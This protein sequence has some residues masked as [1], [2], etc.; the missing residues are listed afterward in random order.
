MGEID[1]LMLRYE[2]ES[3]W[4]YGLPAPR[5]DQPTERERI[6]NALATVGPA[7]RGRAAAAH[8]ARFIDRAAAL[9]P[10][11]APLRRTLDGADPRTGH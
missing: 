2:I 8:K 5:Y 6:R 3:G 4:D 1:D 11:D 7:A 10:D 9:M